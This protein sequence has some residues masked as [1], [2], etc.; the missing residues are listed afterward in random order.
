MRLLRSS[1]PKRDRMLMSAGEN[2]IL[3]RRVGVTA[4]SISVILLPGATSS[5]GMPS[6]SS[7]G[8]AWSCSLIRQFRVPASARD[9]VTGR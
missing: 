8:S 4:Y 9:S 5:R 6:V 1:K 3:P 2:S 7:V